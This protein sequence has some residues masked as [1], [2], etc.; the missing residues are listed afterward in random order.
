MTIDPPPTHFSA[1]TASADEG[2]ALVSRRDAF[3]INGLEFDHSCNP[4][5]GDVHWDGVRSLFNGTMLVLAL[6]LGPIYVSWSAVA[7]F[8][9]LCFVTLCCG[10]S[11]GFHR[12]MIHRSFKCPKWLEYAMIYLGTAVGM[13]GPLWTI[14]THDMR[15]WAQRT[16]KCHPYFAHRAHFLRD[17]WWYLHCRMALKHPPKFNPGP[18]IMDDR[19]YRFMQTTA[20]LHQIPIGLALCGLGGI[21][22]LVWGVFVRVA[23]CTTMHWYISRLAHTRGPRSW[24]VDGAGLMGYDVPAWAIPT[25]GESWHN[26]HH[27]FPASARHGLFPGQIDIGF[28]YI[29]LLERLGLAWDIQTPQTLPRRKGLR[30]LIATQQ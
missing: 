23:A 6:T 14:R 22:C 18:E 30:S 17:A 19:F 16:P 28:L 4:V 24:T 1:A 12:R 20:M 7:V 10:H 13:G 29:R 3:R 27:A 11:V 2:A 8:L 25:M 26:N 5:D 21:E 9:A 15:D